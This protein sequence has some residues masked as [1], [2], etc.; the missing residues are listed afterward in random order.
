M[1]IGSDFAL[2]ME[3]EMM[4]TAQK[5]RVFLD[6]QPENFLDSKQADSR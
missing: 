5:F 2:K 4:S 6:L 1:C 3:D